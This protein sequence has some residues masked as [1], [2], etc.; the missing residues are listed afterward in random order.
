MVEKCL[1]IEIIKKE[2]KAR[3]RKS[4]GKIILCPGITS[5]ADPRAPIKYDEKLKKWFIDRNK[6]IKCFLCISNCKNIH[7]NE[8]NFPYLDYEKERSKIMQTFNQD[9][10]MFFENALKYYDE[11]NGLSKWVYVLLRIFGFEVFKEVSIDKD[12]IP[13]DILKLFGKDKRGVYGKSIIADLELEYK[14]KI[15]VFECKLM[16]PTVDKWIEDA[17]LQIGLYSSSQIYKLTSKEGLDVKFVFCY[18]NMAK[19]II[20]RKIRYILDEN[21]PLKQVLKENLPNGKLIV[22]N[23]YDF[24]H[25]LLNNLDIDKKDKN[26]IVNLLENN[27]ITI[28]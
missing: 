16:N 2:G 9:D 7:L 26:E 14:N 18:N 28:T 1:K 15:Y 5:N 21:K 3:A 19:G 11:P 10:Y 25:V 17:L 6:C 12:T 4:L 20:I 22:V 8:N 13:T 24:Y 27:T 23:T